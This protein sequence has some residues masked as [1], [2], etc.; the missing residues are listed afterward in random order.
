MRTILAL[1]FVILPN[2]T[3][4]FVEGDAPIHF[5]G[6]FYDRNGNPTSD[7]TVYV[8][9]LNGTVLGSAVPN[10]FGYYAVTYNC[11]RLGDQY[12]K[13]E[14]GDPAV[15]AVSGVLHPYDKTCEPHYPTVCNL[16]VGDFIA[17]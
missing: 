2:L 11:P 12:F 17:L 10:Q 6:Y 1:S 16:K 13:L 14:L 3:A 9:T 5:E 8:R 7:Y 15:G 4:F